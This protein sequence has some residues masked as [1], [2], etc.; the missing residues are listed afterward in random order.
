MMVSRMDKLA[1]VLSGLVLLAGCMEAAGGPRD[2]E[3]AGRSG[4]PSTSA[5][6][7]YT[8][9]PASGGA[10][11]TPGPEGSGSVKGTVL[12]DQKL[13][14][15][16]VTVE[17]DSGTTRALTNESGRF[18]VLGLPVGVHVFLFHAPHFFPTQRTVEIAD[19]Q[20]AEI[21]V[22]MAID[23]NS[24]APHTR[25]LQQNG[26][27]ACQ[28]WIGSVGC[29]NPSASHANL[30]KFNFAYSGL[31]VSYLEIFWT[32]QSEAL[33]GNGLQD[34]QLQLMNCRGEQLLG[35]SNL[36]HIRFR[37]PTPKTPSMGAGVCVD[38]PN[39]Q[40]RIDVAPLRT[41]QGKAPGI[42]VGEQRYEFYV[43]LFYHFAP[44]ADYSVKPVG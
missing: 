16:N 23:P 17:V 24:T 5:V 33:A 29:Q 2:S 36:R 35:N 4:S 27:I 34:L 13:P 39:I 32:P 41:N 40:A 8:P 20:D 18:H 25:I 30:H 37:L 1:L 21:Q 43:S 31:N 6:V 15:A 42:L 7:S 22:V 11:A 9:G 44:A 3:G 19:G 14:L 12:D 28:A 10:S 38:P 26:L